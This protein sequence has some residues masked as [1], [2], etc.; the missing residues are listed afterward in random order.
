MGIQICPWQW[1]TKHFETFQ[2]F[3]NLKGL[4]LIYGQISI[5]FTF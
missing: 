3:K 1:N 2:N 5:I 4:G